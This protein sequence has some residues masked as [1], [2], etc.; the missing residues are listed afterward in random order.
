ME[1]TYEIEILMSEKINRP[2]IVEKVSKQ[3]GV[4]IL[5]YRNDQL[6]RDGDPIAIMDGFAS[7]SPLS[8]MQ[9]IAGAVNHNVFSD[10]VIQQFVKLTKDTSQVM[11]YKVSDLAIAALDRS[12]IIEYNGDDVT[13]RWLINSDKWFE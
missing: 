8:R 2:G 4:E 12:G 3:R 10:A 6:R 7:P 11:G 1:G 13:I 9:A 5:I